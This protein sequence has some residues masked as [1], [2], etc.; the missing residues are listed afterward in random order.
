[1][2]DIYTLSKNGYAIEVVPKYGMNCTRIFYSDS[3]WELLKTPQNIDLL[4]DDDAFLY[5][6]PVLFFPNR[7]SGGTFKFQNEEYK[8]PVNEA[9]K[10]NFCHGDLHKLPFTVTDISEDSVTGVYTASEINPY[11]TFPHGFVLS[12]Q[13]RISNKGVEQNIEIKN[14]SKQNMPFAIGFHTTFNANGG[15]QIKLPAECEAERDMSSYLPTGKLFCDFA[16][17]SALKN[18]QFLIDGTPVSKLY[19][20]DGCEI[21]AKP[22]GKDA[23]LKYELDP[24]FKYAMLY[25]PDGKDA[26]CIE[27]QTYLTDCLNLD[28]DPY[29]HGFVYIEPSKTLQYHSCI[30]VNK[31]NDF[32]FTI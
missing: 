13:Y 5:G 11:Q 27:P 4:A 1:M 17:K 24:K 7:I 26:V 28:V 23:F 18:G 31:K 21:L 12:I 20:L 14:T 10:N 2:S 19:K 22:R 8:F 15:M 16:E 9:D 25:S 29:E 3:E 32:A 30:S 6:I